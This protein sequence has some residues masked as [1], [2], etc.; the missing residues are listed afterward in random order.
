MS[1]IKVLF[2][3]LQFLA[4]LFGRSVVVVVV[5]VVMSNFNLGYNLVL[6]QIS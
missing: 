2:G 3:F 1:I 6:K 5:I 4:W